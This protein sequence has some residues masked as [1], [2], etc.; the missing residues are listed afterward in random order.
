MKNSPEERTEHHSDRICPLFIQLLICYSEN[1][2]QHISRVRKRILKT[3]GETHSLVG[4]RIFMSN[5]MYEGRSRKEHVSS[6]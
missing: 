6:S 4:V 2:L 5:K 1:R 3:L